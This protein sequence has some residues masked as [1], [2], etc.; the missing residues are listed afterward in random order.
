MTTA[1]RLLT[2]LD[3]L[4]LAKYDA[5]LLQSELQRFEGLLKQSGG[6]Q[7]SSLLSFLV[8]IS[9]CHL[10]TGSDGRGVM[11]GVALLFAATIV[12]AMLREADR[13]FP[14]EAV[15]FAAQELR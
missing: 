9:F 12:P 7:S 11:C 8:C 6:W 4:V 15:Y 13:M 10:I 3:H 14:A 1:V 2:L 5:K